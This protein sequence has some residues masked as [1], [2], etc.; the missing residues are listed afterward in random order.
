M[1][2]YVRWYQNNITMWQCDNVTKQWRKPLF[3]C[4]ICIVCMDMH[5]FCRWKPDRPGHELAFCSVPDRCRW[6]NWSSI[7]YNSRSEP[8]LF[9]LLL[10]GH[11][12]SWNKDTIWLYAGWWFQPFNPSEKYEFVSWDDDIP[13]K[14]NIYIWKIIQMF[15]TTNQLL[16]DI[17][18]NID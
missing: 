15:Q 2:L 7:S 5:G 1:I 17:V 9:F 12:W 4:G 11:R 8:L 16:S 13:N 10:D 3:S 6:S 18:F 14:F